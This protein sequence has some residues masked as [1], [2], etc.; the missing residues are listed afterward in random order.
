MKPEPSHHVDSNVSHC[1]LPRKQQFLA[2][3]IKIRENIH[4]L[5]AN[6]TFRNTL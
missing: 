3:L 6:E 4:T 2:I 5:R 1:Y